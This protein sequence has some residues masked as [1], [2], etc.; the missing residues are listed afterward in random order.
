M[1]GATR[2]AVIIS[3]WG[4]KTLGAAA[5]RC[6][7]RGFLTA[8]AA[9]ALV[10]ATPACSA[11]DA[12]EAQTRPTPRAA[13]VSPAGSEGEVP[14]PT[15]DAGTTPNAL[16]DAA[17]TTRARCGAAPFD[18]LPA[19]TMGNILETRSAASHTV[20][21]L[22]LATLKLKNYGVFS[23]RRGSPRGT[24]GKL[25]RYQTQDRGKAV[26]ATALVTTPATNASAS[27]PEEFPVLL[28]L[29]GTAGFN[30]ACSPSRGIAESSTGGFDDLTGTLAALL[31][32]YGYITVFP[33]YLGLKSFGPPSGQFH[34]Y[35]VGEPTAVASLDAVRAAKKA[36]ADGTIAGGSI[37][38]G[39]LVVVGASQGG[40][41]A[42]FVDR[43]APHYA[44]ELS[45]T[46]AAW[47][48][49]PTDLP[50]HMKSA[51]GGPSPTKAWA[52]IAAF[53]IGAE[54][55]YE[56]SPNGLAGAFQPP[57]D[58]LLF[59]ALSTQ[60]SS[61]PDMSSATPA[62][63]FAAS[64]LAASQSPALLAEPFAC[65]MRESSVATTSFPRA[66]A[67]P[68]MVVLG[69]NDTLV[70]TAVERAS[71]Q[72]LCA[73]GYNLKYRE[74]AGLSHTESVF[75]SWDEW[76]DFFGQRMAGEPQGPTCVV[77]PAAKC[78]SVP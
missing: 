35:L 51:L 40:H 48:I 59:S 65:Y 63:V 20:L 38:P 53:L 50:G 64:I 9:A 21:E 46:A 55:W 17:L 1:G 68:T 77:E 39:Q 16:A 32:S 71:F 61:F 56:S 11:D 34:P 2:V 12:G 4:A 33:D 41:A 69:Q 5:A 8:I 49:P 13:T 7:E 30:D 73:S 10:G 15:P 72:S 29:H 36:L 67:V 54:R 70:N 27:A 47:L 57:Y 45:I 23:T 24:H 60:C 42:A 25:V 75:G 6:L 44:P 74:C 62:T 31:A 58:T 37:V 26:D 14:G 28:F 78:A 3:F 66:S 19:K 18:W 22:N 43:V 52:N 76:L